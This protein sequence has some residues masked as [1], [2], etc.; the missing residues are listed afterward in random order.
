MAED[1]TTYMIEFTDGKRKK[2]TVPSSWKVTFGPVAVRKSGSVALPYKDKMPQALRFY[3]SETKQRAI[4]T[5]VASFRDMS[6][7]IHEERV[8]SQSKTGTIEI[9]G[10]RKIAN[11]RTE[12]KEW[13]NPDDEDAINAP[14]RLIHNTDVTEDED[15]TL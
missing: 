7:E 4:F 5:N 10:S 3:E 13:I 1:K 12:M 2:I 11:F 9:E 8:S 14:A 15:E 6:I